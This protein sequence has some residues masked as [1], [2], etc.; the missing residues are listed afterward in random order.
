[1]AELSLGIARARLGPAAAIIDPD[2]G[3]AACEENRLS[4]ARQA[5]TAGPPSLAIS[6]L[7]GFLGRTERDIAIT[8]AVR[9]ENSPQSAM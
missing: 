6:E 7:L 5:S 3:I 8:A 2:R 9:D 4:R 1:M